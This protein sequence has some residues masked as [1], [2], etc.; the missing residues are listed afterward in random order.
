MDL[1]QKCD[2]QDIL[3]VG[4][5]DEL[6]NFAPF[7]VEPKPLYSLDRKNLFE[8]L[9]EL[10]CQ[11]SNS[12]KTKVGSLSLDGTII[13]QPCPRQV[14]TNHPLYIGQT[15]C[16][17]FPFTDLKY[18]RHKTSKRGETKSSGYALALYNSITNVSLEQQWSDAA[19]FSY[20]LSFS[21]DWSLCNVALLD[22]T[23]VVV[24]KANTY[25][26]TQKN[27]VPLY[28]YYGNWS[29]VS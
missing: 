14:V 5:D 16:N 4:F 28:C 3:R 2:D 21:N 23:R 26:A 27:P 8:E 13:I 10:P 19:H 9:N 15:L 29:E 18:A 20:Y 6:F 11:R 1:R 7:V 25:Q 17:L 12:M 22:D 24:V